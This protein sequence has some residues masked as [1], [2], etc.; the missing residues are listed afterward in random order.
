MA[1]EQ[2][3]Y[4]KC[5]PSIPVYFIPGRGS[6]KTKDYIDAVTYAVLNEKESEMLTGEIYVGRAK[7]Q[8]VSYCEPVVEEPTNKKVIVCMPEHKA[9]MMDYEPIKIE[10][11]IFNNPAT[12]VYWTDGTKT[13]VKC[14]L[15][16]WDP[17]KGLAMAISKK[18]LGNEGNYYETFKKW[19]PEEETPTKIEIDWDEY[20][21]L[22]SLGDN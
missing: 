17:E 6:N 3:L 12:I 5:N 7:G 19:L 10:K 2:D 8:R 22:K 16:E 20:E 13:V 21:R 4:R 11:V 18:T 1:T 14:G 9:W 15:D